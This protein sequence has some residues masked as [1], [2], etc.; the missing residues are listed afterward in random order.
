MSGTT[1]IWS[2]PKDEFAWLVE[3]FSDQIDRYLSGISFDHCTGYELEW[4]CDHMQALRFARHIDAD[5]VAQVLPVWF[6]A[7]AVEHAWVFPVQSV[8]PFTLET[9]VDG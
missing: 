3:S 6:Q 9:K 5:K 8:P 4:S 2:T 7:R 1:S